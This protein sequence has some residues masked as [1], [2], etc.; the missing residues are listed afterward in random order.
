[1]KIGTLVLLAGLGLTSAAQAES[2][3]YMMCN[4]SD[5]RGTG[6]TVRDGV[7]CEGKP[8]VGMWSSTNLPYLHDQGWR[9][10]H[11]A[12]YST[13]MGAKLQ[14]LMVRTVAAPTPTK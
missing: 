3:E 4:T 11:M 13:G 14:F 1:M 5:S 8:G 6:A 9:V 12:A 7:L 2:V 10:E